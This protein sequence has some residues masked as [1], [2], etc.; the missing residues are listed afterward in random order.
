MNYTFYSKEA[1]RVTVVGNYIN[2]RLNIAAAKCSKKDQF[3]RKIGRA[4]ASGR[5]L[6]NKLQVSINLPTCDI[7]TFLN[8]AKEI[9][10]NY[11]E[12]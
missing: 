4:I 9:S 8:Y 6:K 5:L 11:K 12:V 10:T 7:V 2:G 1:P 3:V